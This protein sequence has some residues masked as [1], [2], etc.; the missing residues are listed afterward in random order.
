M[1]ALETSGGVEETEE[2]RELR[3]NTELEEMKLDQ[4][5]HQYYSID[6]TDNQIRLNP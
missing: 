4:T 6:E 5:I 1:G 2:M 3:E